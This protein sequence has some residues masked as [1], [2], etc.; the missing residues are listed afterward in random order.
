MNFVARKVWNRYLNPKTAVFTWNLLNNAVPTDYAMRRKQ[1][2]ITSKCCCCCSVQPSAKTNKH[3]FLDSEVACQVWGKVSQLVDI[4]IN[5]TSILQLLGD[6][7]R[8]KTS[9]DLLH[10][11]LDVLPGMIFWSIWISRCKVIYE[12]T[13]MNEDV[14]I[15]SIQ[16]LVEQTINAFKPKLKKDNISYECMSF[17]DYWILNCLHH[18]SLLVGCPL[19]KIGL[20]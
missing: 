20:N 11:L 3:L 13:A 5:K 10:W 18:Q 17:F 14:I 6:I 15:R 1:I 7:W 2:M 9:S 16:C 4:N 19:R 12:E 8:N